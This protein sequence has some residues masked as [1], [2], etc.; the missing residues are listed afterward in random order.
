MKIP[1]RRGH[2]EQQPARRMFLR[3]TRNT[4]SRSKVERS[5]IQRRAGQSTKQASVIKDS[6]TCM[7]TLCCQVARG[8]AERL[9]KESDYQLTDHGS[10]VQ[11]VLI[12][13]AEQRR[14]QSLSIKRGVKTCTGDKDHDVEHV[15]ATLLNRHHSE[16]YRRNTRDSCTWRLTC[17][18]PRPRTRRQ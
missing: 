11:R 15:T 16:T 8:I 4:T 1:S 6:D 13:S 14:T 12:R 10:R 17:G 9:M 2:H 3:R 7:P 5:R 18:P